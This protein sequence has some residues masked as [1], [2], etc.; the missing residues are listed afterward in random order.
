MPDGPTYCTR[1]PC[2]ERCRTTSFGLAASSEPDFNSPAPSN[3]RKSYLGI[4]PF[5]IVT[6]LRHGLRK[7]AGPAAE[8]R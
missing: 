7:A 4:V 5:S 1:M 2:D 6:F 8:L 3:A